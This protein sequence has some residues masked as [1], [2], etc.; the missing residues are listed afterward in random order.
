MAC[1]SDHSLAIFWALGSGLCRRWL[2]L[3]E[4]SLIS[5]PQRIDASGSVHSEATVCRHLKGDREEAWMH[6]CTT[7]RSP[8]HAVITTS[9]R[10]EQQI[11][12]YESLKSRY[13]VVKC[14]RESE[15]SECHRYALV[16]LEVESDR[17]KCSNQDTA[18]QQSSGDHHDTVQSFKK[19]DGTCDSDP[20]MLSHIFFTIGGW[21][22][23]RTRSAAALCAQLSPLSVS[24]PSQTFPT[25]CAQSNRATWIRSPLPAP[26]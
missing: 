14:C 22:V 16:L 3:A 21:A 9:Q 12:C 23:S 6:L 11:C 26:T 5:R 25:Q 10:C 2:E 4:H 20:E 17:P 1:T 24:V 15:V 19:Q 7:I 13:P 8:M 18:S